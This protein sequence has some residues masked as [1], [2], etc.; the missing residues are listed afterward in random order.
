METHGIPYATTSTQAA[1]HAATISNR[2]RVTTTQH[3]APVGPGHPAG[4]GVKAIRWAALVRRIGNYHTSTEPGKFKA[5]NDMYEAA[6]AYMEVKFPDE[7]DEHRKQNAPDVPDAGGTRQTALNRAI[8]TFKARGQINAPVNDD[9]VPDI[10][11]AILDL[12]RH[13]PRIETQVTHVNNPVVQQNPPPPLNAPVAQQN[14]PPQMPGLVP[15]GTVPGFDTNALVPVNIP[16]VKA[17]KKL[18]GLVMD[19]QNPSLWNR[20]W[21]SGHRYDLSIR[22]LKN[23]LGRP[24]TPQKTFRQ[25]RPEREY[26]L[27]HLARIL[28]RQPGNNQPP[29]LGITNPSAV[30]QLLRVIARHVAPPAATA[31]G[32]A[33]VPAWVT[34]LDGNAGN[35][36]EILGEAA[37][38]T[39][40]TRLLKA[41][42][43]MGDFS[44]K[45]VMEMAMDNFCDGRKVGSAELR[46]KLFAGMV[47]AF[48]M[49]Q[50]RAMPRDLFR[51]RYQRDQFQAMLRQNV[52][53]PQVSPSA[54]AD[55]HDAFALLPQQGDI[56]ALPGYRPRGLPP[57]YNAPPPDYAAT[58]N[59]ADADNTQS[60]LQTQQSPV[61]DDTAV[62]T[63]DTTSPEATETDPSPFADLA[64]LAQNGYL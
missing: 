21:S 40:L 51:T 30:H 38:T 31:T 46:V 19:V 16:N 39:L 28:V 53:A 14:P 34:H 61:P 27:T 23:H 43:L 15:I 41:S 55:L 3:P 62:Q 36:Q 12:R 18:I 6:I 48:A 54:A 47:E 10:I 25:R 2:T 24:E 59:N 60:A 4:D 49:N 42:H 22:K 26:A 35:P 52:L 13:M 33:H 20:T 44:A 63:D 11:K 58:A 37:R 45:L 5:Y 1:L 64:Y 9:V 29:V 56:T 7:L 57:Q 32:I 50:A 17:S 8:D